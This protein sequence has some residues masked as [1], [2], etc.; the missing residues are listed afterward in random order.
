MLCVQNGHSIIN[1]LHTRLS[2][3]T[4]QLKLGPIYEILF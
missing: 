2:L 1:S 4:V 3:P